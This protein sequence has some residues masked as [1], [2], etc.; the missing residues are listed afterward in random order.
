MVWHLMTLICSGFEISTFGG[1]LFSGGSLISGF[2]N[3]CDILSLLS[4]LRYFR[5]VVTLG[6][7]RYINRMRCRAEDAG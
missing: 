2:A 7:L 1:S 6:T 3:T 5:G 4:K